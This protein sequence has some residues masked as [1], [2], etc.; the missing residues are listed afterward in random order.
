MSSVLGEVQIPLWMAKEFL[1]VCDPE[2]SCELSKKK[3]LQ[4]ALLLLKNTRWMDSSE[5]SHIEQKT[6]AI[7]KIGKKYWPESSDELA[8]HNAIVAR[9][10]FDYLALEQ[11]A[12][13]PL[14][15]SAYY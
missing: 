9:D 12:K 8:Y 7:L 2:Q 1:D 15:I 6:R 3:Q 11:Y 5:A 14:K 4:I 13:E 10:R